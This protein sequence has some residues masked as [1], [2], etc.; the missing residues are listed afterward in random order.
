MRCGMWALGLLLSLWWGLLG[1]Y[2]LVLVAVSGAVVRVRSG[3]G[4]GSATGSGPDGPGGLGPVAS[5]VLTVTGRTGASLS[6]AP[7]P[8]GLKR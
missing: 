4:A 2:R 5:G 7:S 3:C 6:D 1:Q 8:A